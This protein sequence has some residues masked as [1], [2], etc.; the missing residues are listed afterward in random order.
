M[1]LFQ[2]SLKGNQIQFRLGLAII[3]NKLTILQI[4]FLIKISGK[5]LDMLFLIILNA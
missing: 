2:K 1:K 3:K 5:I 4:T